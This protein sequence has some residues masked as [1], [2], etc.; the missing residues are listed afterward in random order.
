[1]CGIAGVIT[2]SGYNLNWNNYFERFRKSMVHRGPDEWG[3]FHNNGLG[4]AHTRLSIIDR[5][6]GRQPIFN[7]DGSIG[8]V[9]NGEI[10]NY[11]ELKKELQSLDYR[12]QTKTD[13]E[14]IVK[15]FEEFGVE[16]FN[17]FNG[18]F[19]FCLWDR[20][21]ERTYLVRDPLGIKPLYMYEDEKRYIFSSELKT[22]LSIKDVDMELNPLGFQ[23]YLTFRYIQSPYTFFK[24]IKSVEAGTYI[25]FEGC[26]KIQLRYWDIS[27]S[28]SFPPKDFRET[29]KEL[30][31][32]LHQAVSSQL[33]GE[34]GIGV[35]LSGGLDSSAIAYHVHQCGAN[36][37]TYNIGFPDI[38]EFQYSRSIAK[39]YDL[40][41]VE[42]ETTIDELITC[43]DRI[44]LALDS[45]IADPAC[46]PLYRLGDVL[47]DQVT[48]VLSGE[49]ADELFG[50]YPQYVNA[51]MEPNP[52]ER[53]F[54]KFLAS[55]SYYKYISNFLLDKNLPPSQFRFKKYFDEEPQP[56]GMLAYDMKTWLPEN[57]MMKADKILMAHSLE[58]RFPFLDKRLVEFSTQ[59]CQDY[60]LH[61]N[62]LGKW[63]LREAMNKYLPKN[64]LQRKKMG[65]TVPV[66][67]LLKKL[68]PTVLE[69][70]NSPMKS[71]LEG[72][73]DLNEIK[74]TVTTYYKN[75]EGSALQV[76]TLFIMLYWHN[77][78]IA[79]YQNLTAN[80]PSR[81]FVYNP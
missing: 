44:V 6:G 50:G 17:K 43:L 30:M 58:G 48:V 5:A 9:Y 54:D 1:M 3:E 81:R 61:P 31:K 34:V 57:L 10:Y 32:Y 79:K 52:Q 40:Q 36:L 47:K 23:D 28:D 78:G 66:D 55:S 74:K 60:K 53:M 73:L 41:Y 22:I 11:K 76:W 69:L 63:I 20:D 12:F 7:E 67:Q 56:N 27:Y 18:M 4:L 29:S 77:F 45:P 39:Q 59:T 13:S 35:L 21:K 19:C 64:I 75:T 71:S 16:C 33:M 80:M 49:G 42:I 46:L 51:C 2:K 26:K 62:G 72:V 70:V 15:A 65:F 14:V 24:R 25:L 8:L 68:K 37:T 38:N